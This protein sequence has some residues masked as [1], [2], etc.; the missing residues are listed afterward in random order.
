VSWT[1]TLGQVSRTSSKAQCFEGLIKHFSL[2]TS[3]TTA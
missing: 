3:V 2:Q 1:T